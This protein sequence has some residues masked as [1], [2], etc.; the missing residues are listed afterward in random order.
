M[1]KLLALTVLALIMS[2]VA[3]GSGPTAAATTHW[4]NDTDPNGGGYSP[5]GT[6]CTDPGYATL[7]SAI[8]AASAGDTI[9]VCDGTYAFIGLVSVN[10]SVTLLGAQ[11]GVDACAARGAESVLS[12]SQGMSVSASDVV[13][14]GFTVEN[15]VVAAFTGYGIWLNPGV[16]GTQIVNNIIQDNI[17]G[18]GLANAGSSQALI[19]HNLLQ[20]NNSPGGASGSGIYTDQFVGGQVTNV[21]IDDNCFINNDNAGV[22]FSSTDILNPTS[23]IEISNNSFDQNGRGIYFYN[24]NNATVHDNSITNSTVPTDGGTSVAIAAFG[25]VNGLT[26]L[27]NDLLTGALRGIRVGSFLVNPNSNVEAHLNNI[28]GFAL[29]GLFVDPGGHA[30]TLNADC[31]WWGSPTGPTHPNNPGGTGDDVIDAPT[32]DVADYTPWLTA[33]APG[34]PCIGGIPNT[35]G[36]VTGGGQIEDPVFSP[37]GDLISLP[38]IMASTSGGAQANFGFVIQFAS[39]DPAP[40]GNLVYNDKG[41]GVRIKATSYDTLIIGNGICGANT[42]ATFTGTANVNGTPKSMTVEVDDCG[43]PG[44]TTPGGPDTFSITTDNYSNSGPL[45]S[46][47]IQIHKTP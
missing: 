28:V 18:V 41:A 22:G 30:G 14:D 39:G 11:A 40:K 21:L 35:P 26:I 25:D 4:V 23:D 46:G 34:G 31:N 7:Q 6:S 43:E 24:T 33:A 38:A 2:L 20:N 8:N 29:A 42:H 10:K 27:N 19:Q 12:N 1:R 5:P 3:V 47:N 36:K 9:R 15:S 44:S 37:L 13:I 17:V 45:I 32:F 16:S